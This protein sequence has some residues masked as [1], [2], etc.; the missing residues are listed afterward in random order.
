MNLLFCLVYHTRKLQ[1]IWDNAQSLIP[2]ISL[3]KSE[4][5]FIKIL[6]YSFLFLSTPARG[7]WGRV[8][9]DLRVCIRAVPTTPPW[10]RKKIGP[11]PSTCYEGQANTSHLRDRL[12]LPPGPH[13]SLLTLRRS[14]WPLIEDWDMYMAWDSLRSS[15]DN[16][17]VEAQVLVPCDSTRWSLRHLI[18]V[19][20]METSSGP[21]LAVLLYSEH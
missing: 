8:G 19:D 17:R 3:R 20:K 21:Q 15:Y 9:G 4:N 16:V 18:A 7:V 5:F 14:P 2:W 10:I 1:A 12:V 13:G 6:I 11:D